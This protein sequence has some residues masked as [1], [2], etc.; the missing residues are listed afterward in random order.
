MLWPA[1]VFVDGWEYDF[2]G[3]SAQVRVGSAASLAD[4]VWA[5]EVGTSDASWIE[6]LGQRSFE[7]G[8]TLRGG[9]VARV[10]NKTP[11]V[12]EVTSGTFVN[13]KRSA[14]SAIL[15]A[16]FPGRGCGAI[17]ED[18]R[19]A[20]AMADQ[21]FVTYD[22]AHA[23]RS[24]TKYADPTATAHLDFVP[25]DI[26]IVE[27]GIA[28]LSTN[29]DASST[30]LHLVDWNGKELWKTTVAFH[31]DSPP[32][33][34]GGGR[35]YL[36]GNGFAAVDNGKTLWADP[37]AAHAY[38]TS[39]ADGTLLLAIG[40]ELRVVNRDGKILQSLRIPEGDPIVAP[41]AVSADGTTWLVTAKA[42]Y[43]AR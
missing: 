18:R 39:L 28:L 35:V 33:E 14:V 34:G 12:L 5:I 32:I 23:D 26:S 4:K 27:R 8:V 43:V 17:A 21:R 7:T 10:W 13:Q 3:R 19:I 42:L 38:G 9:G 25:Y 29:A 30:T 40:P 24:G 2:A 16:R 22:P 1:T 6:Q 11:E 41:P 15:S 36:V 31:V 37:S 20:I